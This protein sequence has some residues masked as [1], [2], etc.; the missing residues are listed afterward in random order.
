MEF[1]CCK[2][3]IPIPRVPHAPSPD[4]VRFICMTEAR[5]TSLDKSIDSMTVSELDHIVL[6]LKRILAQL[7]SVTARTLGSVTGGPYRKHLLSRSGRP[8]PRLRQHRPI[9]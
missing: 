2:T 3:P 9:H 7:Q 8:R 6:Q 5:G 4:R 1:I